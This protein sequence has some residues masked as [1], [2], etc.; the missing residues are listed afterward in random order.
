MECQNTFWDVFTD[1]TGIAFG[2]SQL[3]TPA[4]TMLL[5]LC[6]MVLKRR[7]GYGEVEVFTKN[8]KADAIGALADA[9]LAT[10]EEFLRKRRVSGDA[11]A[12][13]GRESCIAMLVQELEW[14]V[15]GLEAEEE[16]KGWLQFGLPETA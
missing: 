5:V 1:Q 4:F 2:N 16:E 6:V 12:G 7:C 10:K 11:E 13:R 14:H 8:A 9:I 3:I 15:E